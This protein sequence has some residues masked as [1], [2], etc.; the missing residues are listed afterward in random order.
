MRP[1]ALGFVMRFRIA[2]RLTQALHVLVDVR[3][4]FSQRDAMIADGRAR[5]S[6]EPQTVD[7]PRL[8]GK[9][10]RSCL[11]EGASPD[12]GRRRPVPRPPRRPD[13]RAAPKPP[14]DSAGPQ[15]R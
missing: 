3:A 12:A 2:T 6:S 15:R 7:A 11:L 5:A 4:A 8:R 9:E 1:P 10:R 14:T 13:M